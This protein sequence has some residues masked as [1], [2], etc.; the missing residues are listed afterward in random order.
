[1]STQADEMIVLLK[2]I[3]VSL[4]TLVARKPSGGRGDGAKRFADGGD[5]AGQK[6]CLACVHRFKCTM[7][8]ASFDQWVYTTGMSKAKPGVPE[9]FK[10]GP[11]S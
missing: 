4:K 10:P 9:K 8:C 7:A 6:P 2:S 5:V 3:D 1:M 11:G